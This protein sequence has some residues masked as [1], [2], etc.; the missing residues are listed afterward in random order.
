MKDSIVYGFV[1]MA[2]AVLIGFLL[3]PNKQLDFEQPTSLPESA[4]FEVANQEPLQND[5]PA[6]EFEEKA[7][8]NEINWNQCLDD[9][10][11]AKCV[12]EITPLI[13][14]MPVLGY[15]SYLDLFERLDKNVSTL[16]R[17]AVDKSCAPPAAGWSPYSEFYA[18]CGAE[19]FAEIGWLL[20]DCFGHN[21]DYDPLWEL[22]ES[23]VTDL[24]RFSTAADQ[25]SYTQA[26]RTWLNAKCP[27]IRVD[28][29][30]L[31]ELYPIQD[32]SMS[33]DELL[34]KIAAEYIHRSVFLG[35]SRASLR[36]A[37][38]AAKVNAYVDMEKTESGF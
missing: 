17:V 11:A 34:E 5:G 14:A 20:R 25:Y 26:E 22:E 8:E 9:I 10:S 18:R 16:Q 36:L 35:D 23:G 21:Q 4:T 7:E 19:A 24:A 31:P 28:M 15:L 29:T 13:A 37:E 38:S 1:L 33:S 12:E 27:S 6:F 32:F 30:A 2:A 3:L